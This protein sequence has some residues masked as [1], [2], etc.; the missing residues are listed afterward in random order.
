MR[1]AVVTDAWEPQ[2]N[3]VVNTLKAT[4]ACLRSMEHEVLAVTPEGL[5]SFPCPTYP[6]IRLAYQPY[7]K[8]ASKLDAFAPDCIHIATEGP[9]G[10]AARRYCLHRGLDFTTAYHTRFPEYVQARTRIPLAWT[11]RWLRWFHGPSKAIMVPTLRVKQVLEQHGFRRVGLWGRGVDTDHF[12]PTECDDSGIKRPLFLYVG[13]LA[14]EKNVEAFLEMELPGTKWLIGDG[15]QKDELEKKYPK[16]RFLGAKLHDQLPG[17]YNCADVFVF[18]SKTDTFGLV[19]AEAMACGVPVAAYQVE[20]PIDVVANGK[21]GSLHLDLRRACFE[22]LA[23]DRG[24]V[25]Q[26]ALGFS[27]TSATQ[28]FLQHLHPVQPFLPKKAVHTAIA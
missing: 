7:N 6:D 3:G 22:A 10:L 26:H 19:L 21:S 20:G 27:W 2:V 24:E 12:V 15:P 8:V 11:Y 13:R 17:Y 18:P 28:Q 14:V 23:M 5:R 1:I 16:A 9:M 25:R 4:I